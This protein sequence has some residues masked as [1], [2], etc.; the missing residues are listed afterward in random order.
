M[1]NIEEAFEKGM[2]NLIKADIRLGGSGLRGMSIASMAVSPEE[3]VRK[4]AGE[5]VLDVITENTLRYLKET[6]E[7]CRTATDEEIQ[8][9]K[10]ILREYV[11]EIVEEKIREYASERD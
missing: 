11:R 9:I 2:D 8:I 5:L 6:D 10:P 7:T 4:R 3:C 1:D